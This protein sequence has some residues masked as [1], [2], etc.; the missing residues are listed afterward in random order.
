ML[1]ERHYSHI[2]RLLSTVGDALQTLSA[3]AGKPDRN[4]PAGAKPESDLSEKERLH[5]AG[6]MRVNHS[7]EVCAQ[8]LYKGQALTAKL[9]TVREKME[10]AAQEEQDHLAW[11]EERLKELDSQTSILNPLWYALSFGIGATTGLI[12]D[13]L[14]LGFVAATEDQV[15]EH[16]ESHLEKLPAQDHRSRAIV[17]QMR[18]EEAEHSHMATEAGGHQF[19]VPVKKLMSAISTAMTSTSYRI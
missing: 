8:A 18:D 1:M 2:D 15:C 5:A 6:L 17:A 19:P 12:S 14:S 16:L 13:R 7:G 3:P 4:S 10:R 9:P 11:C